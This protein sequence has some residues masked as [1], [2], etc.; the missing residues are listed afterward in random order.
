[1]IETVLQ[2]FLKVV[3]IGQALL[4]LGEDILTRAGDV[5]VAQFDQH[6]GHPADC[7]NRLHRVI[8]PERR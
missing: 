8:F 1:M 2:F 3:Q 4:D 7:P 6:L 5:F